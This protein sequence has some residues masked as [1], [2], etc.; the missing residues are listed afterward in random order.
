MKKIPLSNGVQ[1]NNVGATAL[2]KVR[3]DNSTTSTANGSKKPKST[4]NFILTMLFSSSAFLNL[5]L[6]IATL[7]VVFRKR[8]ITQPSGEIQGVGLRS[9]TY[10]ELEGATN[11][12]K[13]ELGKGACSTVTKDFLLL[14]TTI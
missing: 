13:E 11:D 10:K 6:L 2:V 9:L 3:K 7:W 4:L 5:V 12:F 14:V 1:F 8:R